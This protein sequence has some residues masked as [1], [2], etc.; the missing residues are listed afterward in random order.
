MN[1]TTAT[2]SELSSS[3]PGW[4]RVPGNLQELSTAGT[5]TTKPELSTGEIIRNKQKE[6]KQ[7]LMEMARTEYVA[8]APP[9]P[10]IAPPGMEGPEMRRPAR[11]CKPHQCKKTHEKEMTTTEIQTTISLP[12][13]MREVLWTASSFEPL[14][15]G[16]DHAETGAPPQ[17]TGVTGIMDYPSDEAQPPKLHM[18]AETGV[19]NGVMDLDILEEEEEQAN[20]IYSIH[21]DELYAY[22]FTMIMLLLILL[23]NM[24]MRLKSRGANFS[25]DE[26]MLDKINESRGKDFQILSKIY[27]QDAMHDVDISPLSEIDSKMPKERK[28]RL[29]RGITIDSGAGNSVMPRRMVLN[30]SSI[31]ESAGSRAGVNYVPAGGGKIP[32]EGEFDLAFKTLEGN[33]ETWTFQ[34]AEINKALGAVS[35]LVDLGYTVIFDKNLE[36]GQDMSYMTHKATNVVSRLRRERNVW[37]LD[38]YVSLN[39]NNS[40]QGFH[41]RG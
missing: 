38:A 9:V 17:S 22:V 11:R 2:E 27:D 31:R 5:T 30:K 15:D 8:S 20:K 37:V 1:G 16:S 14:V 10:V 18:N 35:Q 3:I 26:N 7:K 21:A 23:L 12:H 13:T 33:A 40:E 41:R 24:D 32:N 6:L 29:K 19:G 28:M 4:S 39:T 34:V 25:G 36:T